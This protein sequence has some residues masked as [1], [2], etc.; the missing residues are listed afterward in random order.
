MRQKGMESVMKR[1]TAIIFSM[2]LSLSLL[3]GCGK[4]LEV[5]E[6]TV[7]VDKNGSV[8]SVD[9]ESFEKDY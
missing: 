8:I 6:S 9:I 5:E 4:K 2:I 3:A 1:K 7:Y